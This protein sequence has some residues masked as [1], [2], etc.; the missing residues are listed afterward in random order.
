[1]PHDLEAAV[2]A[3]MDAPTIGINDL[4]VDKE[5]AK[6][7]QAAIERF[8]CGLIGGKNAEDTEG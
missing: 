7:V 8:L 3:I 6:L 1:M 5:I 4:M 2:Y